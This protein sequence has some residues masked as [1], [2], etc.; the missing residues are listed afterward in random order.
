MLNHRKSI[1]TLYTFSVF[2][3]GV[4]AAGGPQM[5]KGKHPNILFAIA[6][7]QS[8]PYASAYGTR[9]VRTPAFDEVA[10]KGVLFTNAFVGAPQ[11]SPSRAAILT[12]KNIWQLG[13]AGT[14]SSY[15]PQK[16][17]VFT[18]LLEKSGYQIGYTGK[19]WAPGNWKDAG[20]TRNPV[21][22][23]YNTRI[24]KSVPTKGISKTDYFENFKDF[25]AKK[26]GDTPFFFW[27]GGHEP[28]RDYEEGSGLK[29]GKKLSEAVVPSFLPDVDLVKSDVLDYALE[30]EWFDAQLGK[31]I[32]FLREKG[33]LEN[34]I[35]VVTAD[36][37]MPFPSAKANLQEY[38]THVPLA[39]CWPKKIMPERVVNE[40]VGLID[41]APTFLEIAAVQNAPQMT[42]VSLSGLL[43][44][45]K[46]LPAD[47]LRK[48]VLTGRE[49]H[50]HARPDNLGYPAR[51]IRTADYLFILNFKP[52]RWPAGDPAPEAAEVPL[53]AENEKSLWPGYQDIDNSP[54]KIML[55]KNRDK[56][57]EPFRLG[58]EKRPAEELF[59][60]QDDPCCIK[61]LADDPKYQIIKNELRK[62]LEND[63]KAQGDPRMTGKGDIFDSY[64]RFGAMRDLPGF[65][66]KGKYNPKYQ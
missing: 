54:T 52:D 42:G 55:I 25:Y 29:A 40:L 28:H 32:S 11:C 1:C 13:E 7:D 58:Y 59:S 21:G 63:L 18:D 17:V 48:Y 64:P 36:N 37:G 47:P 66:A 62:T 31:M 26:G 65:K 24:F 15:F 56:Y 20:R 35:I 9:G 50:T 39:I 5:E 19:P 57:P 44:A 45:G 2:A 30:I 6:D 46:E 22:P 43:F 8:Y 60:I 12:G 61:N 53:S 14:H 38:G 49:R 51:A 34:T 41:L 27:Y 4:F 10:Q 33:E 3:G 16:L 23:E